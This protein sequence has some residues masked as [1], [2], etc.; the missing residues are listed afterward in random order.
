LLLGSF[1]GFV[2][3]KLG[4]FFEKGEEAFLALD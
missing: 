2:K 1:F 3:I 4:N